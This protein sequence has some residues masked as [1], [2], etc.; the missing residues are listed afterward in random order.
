MRIA[1]IGAG[2]MGGQHAAAY[3]AMPDVTVGA[4]VSRG[5]ERAERLASRLDAAA[6]TR[7]TC[8]LEDPDI[9]AVDVTVPTALHGEVVRRA[10]A[11]G[12]HVFC[13]TPLAATPE[14]AIELRDAARSA[15]RHL[16]VALLMRFARPAVDL[17]DVIGDGSLGD[18]IVV[19]A[20]R[21]AT[22]TSGAHHGDV[23]EEIMLFDLDL[24]CRSLG[25]PTSVSAT[26]AHGP[27][28]RLDHAV[29]ALEWESAR[30]WCEA[31]YLLAPDQPFTSTVLALFSGGALEGAFRAPRDGPPSITVRR[32]ENEG[33]VHVSTDLGAHPVEAECAH[34]VRVA[35]GEEDP[36]LLDV[37]QAIT[38]LRVLRAARESLGTGGRAAVE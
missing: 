26:G 12:K 32:F 5:S 16:Q 13:E 28:G 20:R 27:G 19:T 6:V 23:L 25:V 24:L 17:H 11:A 29:V 37:D 33:G 18:P 2:L 35:R 3:A 10:L 38:G 22:G 31:S 14:E 9:D 30:G 34:F 4:V 36:A 8:V 21:L 15:A 1:L 7:L